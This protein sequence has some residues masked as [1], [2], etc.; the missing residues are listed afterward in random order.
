MIDVKYKN[1][2]N[3]FIEHYKNVHVNPWHEISERELEQLYDSLT[4]SMDINDEYSFK[5]FIDYIIKFIF[6]YY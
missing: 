3:R 1:I 4:N 5:Y 2:Y 6:M